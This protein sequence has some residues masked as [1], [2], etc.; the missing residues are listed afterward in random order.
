MVYLSI[1]LGENPFTSVAVVKVI[2][3]QSLMDL[4]THI[5]CG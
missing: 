2:P 4:D 3:K 5:L 1:T